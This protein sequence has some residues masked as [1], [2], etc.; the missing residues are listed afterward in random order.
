MK[1]TKETIQSILAITALPVLSFSLMSCDGGSDSVGLADDIADAANPDVIVDIEGELT[2]AELL[3]VAE[4]TYSRFKQQL[5]DTGTPIKLAELNAYR[6]EMQLTLMTPNPDC[7]RN[8]NFTFNYD[9][10]ANTAQT[11]ITIG[12]E[13]VYD[14]VFIY[15]NGGRGP[16]VF[17]WQNNQGTTSTILISASGPDNGEVIYRD[18]ACVYKGTFTALET[19]SARTQQKIDQLTS[20][21]MFTSGNTP[22]PKQVALDKRIF[23]LDMIRIRGQIIGREFNKSFQYFFDPNGGI[24][25]QSVKDG[26]TFEDVDFEYI[27]GSSGSIR[28]T[29]G[30]GSNSETTVTLGFT[31][32]NAGN[33]LMFDVR[34][35]VFYGTF[36]TLQLL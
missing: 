7:P 9:I 20:T 18:H 35:N 24:P 16:S 28:I 13:K 12:N 27:Q 36:S 32:A 21:I 26:Q 10:E 5:D 19:A 11:F 15:P 23:Q 34:G 3:E 1:S 31:S 2:E 33:V 4:R 30:Q 17:E 25:I 22:P 29:W 6:R 8:L 14:P